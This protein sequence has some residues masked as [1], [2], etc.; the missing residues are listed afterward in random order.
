MLLTCHSP[1]LIHSPLVRLTVGTVFIDGCETLTAVSTG[2]VVVKWST[3]QAF[4]LESRI[5]ISA[6]EAT[7]YLAS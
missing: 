1:K 5:R 4:T 2:S 3:S 6:P 7:F